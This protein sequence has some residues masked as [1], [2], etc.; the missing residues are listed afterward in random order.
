MYKLK[1]IDS[2][3]RNEENCI[4]RPDFNGSWQV[5]FSPFRPWLLCLAEATVKQKSGDENV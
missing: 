5:S 2:C 1:Y 4:Y 3:N